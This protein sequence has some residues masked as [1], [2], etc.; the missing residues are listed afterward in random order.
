[1]TTPDAVGSA[2]SASK[3]SIAAM[4][5]PYAAEWAKADGR[6]GDTTPGTRNANPMKRK[7]WRMS[8]GG[9]ASTCCQRR[10]SGQM[11]REVTITHAMRLN[12]MLTKKGSCDRINS[13]LMRFQ[14]LRVAGGRSGLLVNGRCRVGR[15]GDGVLAPPHLGV[16]RELR[17]PRERTAQFAV[18]SVQ[19][20]A[21][22]E[23]GQHELRE[24]AKPVAEGPLVAEGRRI[25]TSNRLEVFGGAA[26]YIEHIGRWRAQLERAA[27]VI[28]NV[29]ANATEQVD[30]IAAHSCGLHEQPSWC[31]HELD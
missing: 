12:A 1:M 17:L 6:S 15:V 29:V 18:I 19:I 3:A 22:A 20:E 16:G 7:L 24:L 25:T 27:L 2:I 13:S 4:M 30:W 21:R 5:S 8:R 11:Y 10:S 28:G 26:G 23:R 31:R 14:P 9:N